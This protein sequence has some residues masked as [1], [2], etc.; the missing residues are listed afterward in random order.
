MM[1][2]KMFLCNKHFRKS[3]VILGM[4]SAAELRVKKKEWLLFTYMSEQHRRKK[5]SQQKS[6][7]Y[8]EDQKVQ[9]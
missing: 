3:R 5:V 4:G 7:V 9:R 1:H 6:T 8:K 2:K